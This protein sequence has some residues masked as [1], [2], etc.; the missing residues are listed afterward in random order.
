[1]ALSSKSGVY[2]NN[3][4]NASFG[5]PANTI[6]DSLSTGRLFSNGSILNKEKRYHEAFFIPGKR[7]LISRHILA[8][9]EEVSEFEGED[10]FSEK[11]KSEVVEEWKNENWVLWRRGYCPPPGFDFEKFAAENDGK[12][13]NEWSCILPEWYFR[14][15]KDRPQVEMSP[16]AKVWMEYVGSPIFP[17]DLEERRKLKGYTELRPYIEAHEKLK[18]SGN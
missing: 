7:A 9:I 6:K 8:K 17:F 4:M 5:L 18:K 12:N 13:Y 16:L 14:D 10:I 15:K 3:Q 11:F 2:L 1:M